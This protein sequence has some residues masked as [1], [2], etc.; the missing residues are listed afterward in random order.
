MFKISFG[1]YTCL[2]YRNLNC[3]SS[4]T[5]NIAVCNTL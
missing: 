5:D 1:A 4:G 2:M 3:K